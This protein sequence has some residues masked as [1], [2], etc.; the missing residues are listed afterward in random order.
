MPYYEA[1]PT[2]KSPKVLSRIQLMLRHYREMGEYKFS[3]QHFYLIR[4]VKH[5]IDIIVM[6]ITNTVQLTHLIF[7]IYVGFIVQLRRLFC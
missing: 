3:E 5:E 4:Y 7:L 6:Y 2:Q 1:S